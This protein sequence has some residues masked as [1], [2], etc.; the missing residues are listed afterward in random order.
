[1]TNTPI[2]AMGI[3]QICR[4]HIHKLGVVFAMKIITTSSFMF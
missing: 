2:A 3:I 4:Y 1:M